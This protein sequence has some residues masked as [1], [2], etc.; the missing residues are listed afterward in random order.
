MMQ[1]PRIVHFPEDD[2][3]LD[4]SL[5]L[6]SLCS[7]HA[8]KD[9][10]CHFH[11]DLFTV[12]ETKQPTYDVNGITKFLS[13]S[14][15]FRDIYQQSVAAHPVQAHS[16]II[17]EE[18]WLQDHQSSNVLPF[19]PMKFPE[20]SQKKII[21]MLLKYKG[22]KV[23]D[24]KVQCDEN[25][26]HFLQLIPSSHDWYLKV[27]EETRFHHGNLLMFFEDILCR[28]PCRLPVNWNTL[29][30]F[31]I[32]HLTSSSMSKNKLFLRTES[33]KLIQDMKEHWPEESIQS[34]LSF[35]KAGNTELPKETRVP[36]HLPA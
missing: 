32:T 16:D 34:V 25:Q 29:I 35:L 10:R 24:G 14:S 31:M 12:E 8:E 1:F 3:E 7:A 28:N 19:H 2:A 11:H 23:K 20:K 36:I 17:F 4:L 5:I 18:C 27:I 26:L 6:A 22:L 30:N 33:S 21:E 9:L 15:T 13:N